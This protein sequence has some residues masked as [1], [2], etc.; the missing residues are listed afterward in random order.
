V[1]AGELVVDRTTMRPAVGAMAMNIVRSPERGPAGQGRYLVA[2]NSGYGVQFDA[3][4]NGSQQSL[5]VIDLTLDPPQVIQNVYFP[6]PQSASVGAVFDP[7]PRG[8][9]YLL[10]VSGGVENRVWRLTFDPASPTPIVEASPGPDTR[11]EAEAISVEGF[12]RQARGKPPVRLHGCR[13]RSATDRTGD[14][15]RRGRADSVAAGQPAGA[16]SRPLSRHD[17]QPIARRQPAI[18]GSKRYYERGQHHG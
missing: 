14:P 10:Y 16:I 11:V 18:T 15:T 9:E 2:V 12:A 7:R 6:S 5:Q 4:T 1:P 3:R 13:T 17:K 8:G